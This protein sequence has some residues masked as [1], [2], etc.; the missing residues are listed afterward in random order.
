MERGLNFV[1]LSR[2]ELDVTDPRAV[3]EAIRV[4][5]PWAVVNAAGYVR[6]DE[7]ERDWKRCHR[8]NVTGTSV[9]ASACAAADVQLLVFSSDLIFDGSIA[10][11]YLESDAP[12]PLNDYGRSKLLAEQAAL[13][14]YPQALIARTSAFFGPWDQYNFLTTTLRQL[15]E[16]R[17]V[18][19]A[20][21]WTISP[22]Y[23]VDLVH[24][25]L[26]LLVDRASGIWHL[27]N[28]GTISW[29]NFAK[30]AARAKGLNA[31]AVI[32]CSGRDLGLPAQRPHYSAL[33]SCR[34]RLLPALADAVERYSRVAFTDQPNTF[35]VAIR[36][37]EESSHYV[38]F[39][40]QR[41]SSTSPVGT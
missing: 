35:D 19:A 4:H 30:M 36:P 37:D 8:T 31:Q 16:G 41:S 29:S 40:I 14:S 26:D 27:S 3:A 9:V 39:N 24:R 18:F 33:G 17:T 10:R 34:G 6:V 32:G 23:V 15:R 13:E 22:T 20:D 11:P 7:A 12:C 1:G 38:D 2:H 28:D 5:N 25:C 21:D